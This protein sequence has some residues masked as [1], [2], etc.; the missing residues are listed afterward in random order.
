MNNYDHIQIERQ[1][2]VSK[3]RGRSNPTAP[4]PP[5]RSH[6]QHGQKLCSELSQASESILSTRRDLGIQTDSLM[7]LEIS[8]EAL[9]SEILEL[10]VSR[11][12]L[13]LVEEMPI[14]GSTSSKLV[15]QFENQAA[16]NQFN[17]ERAL[18]ESDEHADSELLTYAKRR[19]LFCCIEAI[20]SLTCE[21]R[22]GSKLKS[23]ME[24]ITADTGYFIVNIDVWFNNDRSKILEIQ[25]QIQQ[26]LGTQ[27]SQLL[28]DLFE[29]SGLL[30]GRVRVNEFSLNALLNLDIVCLVELPY[31]PISQEPFELYSH[32]FT[33]IVNDTLDEN[34]PLAAVLDSGVFTGNPL[35][36][37]VVVA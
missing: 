14:T 19:D 21:D 33:P 13:Y 34:A 36:R 37:T 12:N 26:A 4:K 30:L 16:I 5:T 23:F 6:A 31:E 2:I 20:R 1:E 22:I 35:L 10:L 3:Y 15:V 8:S 27:G 25:R 28:G 29:I 24:N 18:W 17:A 7:V 9:P 11:F 32:D